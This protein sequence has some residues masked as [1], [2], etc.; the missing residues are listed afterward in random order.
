M[1]LS[2]TDILFIALGLA[3]GIAVAFGAGAGLVPV[4][5]AFPPFVWVLI[6]LG[7]VE[8]ALTFI[9]RKP[10]GTLVPLGVRLA[11]LAAGAIASM[12]LAPVFSA[13]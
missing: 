6:G 1:T 12:V 5:G 2:R 10:P 8:V 4:D 3:V 13:S 7:I 11:A 9:T